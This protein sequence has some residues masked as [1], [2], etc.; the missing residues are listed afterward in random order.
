[1]KG[2]FKPSLVTIVAAQCLPM[3]SKNGCTSAAYFDPISI[4]YRS[5]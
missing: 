3:V 1:M 2:Y 4:I 5:L